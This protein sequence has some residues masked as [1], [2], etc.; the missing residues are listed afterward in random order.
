MAVAARTVPRGFSGSGVHT[1]HLQVCLW[2]LPQHLLSCSQ[3]FLIPQEPACQQP[4][5]PGHSSSSAEPGLTVLRACFPVDLL[6]LLKWKA[7]PDRIMD[8]LGR[9]R[10][11]SGEEIVKVRLPRAPERESGQQASLPPAFCQQASKAIF[12]IYN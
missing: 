10:H 4:G 12:E 2:P 8:I 5:G 7:F 1:R 3:L 6:A 11:V 9:L